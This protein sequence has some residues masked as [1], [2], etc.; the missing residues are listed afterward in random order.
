MHY[1][2]A[3]H[4]PQISTLAKSAIHLE[5]FSYG[6]A[7]FLASLFMGISA[8]DSQLAQLRS[9]CQDNRQLFNFTLRHALN[10]NR[11]SHT[12]KNMLLVEVATASAVVDISKRVKSS[13][14]YH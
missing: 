14:T 4:S 7:V 5:N 9:R 8:G 1:Y 6:Q 3:T 11:S 2:G 13:M 10:I 12:N